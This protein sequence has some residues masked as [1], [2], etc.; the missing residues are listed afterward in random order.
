MENISQRV[1]YV[2]RHLTIPAK[3][4]PQTRRDTKTQMKGLPRKMA[5]GS[6]FVAQQ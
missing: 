4:P 5:L 2:P 3:I 1:V 6:T